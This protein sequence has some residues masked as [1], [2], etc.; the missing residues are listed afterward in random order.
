MTQ[1]ELSSLTNLKALGDPEKFWSDVTFLLVLTKECT[2][3][4]RVYILAMMWIHPYQ[5]SVS[6]IEETINQLT[7]LT[8]TGLN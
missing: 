2:V 4:E 5:A 7:P 8:P 3:G 1:S 6:T